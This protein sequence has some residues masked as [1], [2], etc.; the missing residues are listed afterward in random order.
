MRR[1]DASEHPLA[2]LLQAAFAEQIA[3][4]EID[5]VAT[6]EDNAVEIQADDWTLVLEEWPLVRAWLALD[7]SPASEAE[8]S[9]ALDAAI[10]PTELAAL[11][12]ADRQLEGRLTAALVDSGDDLSQ[13]LASRLVD[14]GGRVDA[15]QDAGESG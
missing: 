7:E 15:D 9:M 3:S 2:R 4:G 10:A 8:R 12:A 11:R 5:V 14:A 6:P 1:P 13:A